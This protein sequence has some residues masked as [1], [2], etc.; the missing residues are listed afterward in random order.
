MPDLS[1]VDGQMAMQEHVNNAD[2]IVLD[3]VA[4]LCRTG[5]PNTSEAW[6][7]TQQWLLQLRGAK[8]KTILIIDHAGKNGSNRCARC[9]KQDVLKYCSKSKRPSGYEEEQKARF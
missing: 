5:Q 3:N 2:F 9:T 1:L 4:T 7:A 8:G 6:R